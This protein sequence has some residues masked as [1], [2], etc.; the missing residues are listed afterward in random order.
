MNFDVLF[1]NLVCRRT[2]DNSDV[3]YIFRFDNGYGASLVRFNNGY[4]IAPLRFYS[5][6]IDYNN[7]VIGNDLNSDA[8]ISYDTPL[9]TMAS[10]T[11]T[12]NVLDALQTISNL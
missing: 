2:Q 1:N 6:D 8:S 4:S 5:D 9:D 3:Q 7:I 11:S 10:Y 12:Y